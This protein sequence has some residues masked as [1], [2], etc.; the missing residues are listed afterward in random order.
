MY[1]KVLLQQRET[2][3]DVK[4]HKKSV[5]PQVKVKVRLFSVR[6]NVVETKILLLVKELKFSNGYM[7]GVVVRQR[8]GVL[9]LPLLL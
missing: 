2:S 3:F 4:K 5:D 6:R 9:T 8:D 1:R 7:C